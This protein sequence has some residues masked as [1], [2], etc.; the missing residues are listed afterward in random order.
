VFALYYFACD[1]AKLEPTQVVNTI[2]VIKAIVAKKDRIKTK[3]LAVEPIEQPE[4]NQ[5]QLLF[6]L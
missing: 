4:Y 2:N 1:R 3:I 5:N 6:N